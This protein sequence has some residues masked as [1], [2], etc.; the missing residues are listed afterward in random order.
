MSVYV[1]KLIRARYPRVVAWLRRF[2]WKYARPVHMAIDRRVWAWI[3]AGTQGVSLR[4]CESCAFDIDPVGHP[5]THAHK[6]HIHPDA[7]WGIYVGAVDDW[8]M[9]CLCG[10]DAEAVMK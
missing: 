8:D 7:P 2:T 3:D 1:D 4:K 5:M 9:C 10:K 6:W